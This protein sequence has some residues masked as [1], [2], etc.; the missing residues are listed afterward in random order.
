MNVAKREKFVL[1]HSNEDKACLLT[2][3]ISFEWMSHYHTTA[4]FAGAFGI[5]AWFRLCCGPPRYFS[6]S[7]ALADF[8]VL[9]VELKIPYA[10]ESTIPPKSSK[11]PRQMRA[12]SIYY[13]Q[14]VRLPRLPP[15]TL[16]HTVCLNHTLNDSSNPGLPSVR[17]N[18]SPSSAGV[19]L[20]LVGG[21]H[22][23]E[24]YSQRSTT[25]HNAHLILD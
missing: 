14:T 8:A 23:S 12:L 22:G 1:P 6:W 18:S 15:P 7:Q 3:K 2:L 9:S 17:E 11:V 21:S 20:V 24:P 4:T 25:P 5:K 10:L 16:N 13:C 19:F